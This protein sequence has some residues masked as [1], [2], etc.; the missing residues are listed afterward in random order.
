MVR[1]HCIELPPHDRRGSTWAAVIAVLFA[2]LAVFSF[3][4]DQSLTLSD[5]GVSTPA[6]ATGR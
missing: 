3:A 4:V 5:P 2:A 1:A 6:G